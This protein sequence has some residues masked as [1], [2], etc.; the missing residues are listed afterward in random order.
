MSKDP[1][2]FSRSRRAPS[3]NAIA[4]PALR[5]GNRDSST[6]CASASGSALFAQNNSLAEGAL[7]DC[8]IPFATLCPYNRQY[9][10]SSNWRAQRCARKGSARGSR[11]LQFRRPLA[12]T[13]PDAAFFGHPLLSLRVSGNLHRV[14]GTRR[15]RRFRSY[16]Q[17][18]L[19]RFELRKLAAALCIVNAI[20]IPLAL[21]IVLHVP[22]SLQLTR[23]NFLRLTAIYI[24]SAIPFFVTGIEMSRHLWA[25]VSAYFPP[26]Q[27]RSRWRR[28]GLPG[29]SFHC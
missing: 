26:L 17:D 25:P 6:L 19:S 7:L 15:G 2:L 8:R 11:T 5:A 12:G 18:S 10:W 1:Y 20:V 23:Q 4:P 24:Y 27:R 28:H 22:V 14:A 9:G 16:S 3:V 13:D 29:L 21:E